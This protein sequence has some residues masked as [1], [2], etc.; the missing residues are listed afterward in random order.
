[1]RRWSRLGTLVVLVV[2]VGLTA[3][4]V[5]ISRRAGNVP[6]CPVRTAAVVLDPGHGGEDPGA[7]NDG[8]GLVER[9]LTLTIARRTAALLRADGYGV[10][11]TRD[12]DATTLANSP[13]GLI[14]NACGAL[15]YVSIHLNSFT[16]PDPNYAKVFW[17][18]ETKDRSFAEAMRAALVAGLSPGTN[19]DDGGIEQLENGG[20][21]RARMPAALVEPVF[22]SNPTE[23]ARLTAGDGVR[24]EQIAGA[25]ARGVE[26][27]LGRDAAGNRPAPPAAEHGFLRAIDSLRG[28][29]RGSAK[30]AI[31]AAEA[32]GAVRLPDVRAYMAEVYRLA[33][34]VGLD[35]AV[36]VAQSAHETGF[37]RSV[38]WKDHL[39][40]AG[41]GITNDAA[42]SPTWANGTDAARAQIVHLYLYAAGEIGPDHALAPYRS[43]D[44][45]YGVAVKAGR[46]GS[47]RTLADLAGRWASDPDYAAGV[48]RAGNELFTPASLAAVAPQGDGRA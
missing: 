1:M 39:N 47:A 36:V 35:P 32:A 23:A 40:P 37:W 6:R 44:P 12:D 9:D 16:E 38:A 42:T 20:L 29:P 18:I 33:P 14:A 13:R 45:R 25:I 27:W 2:L 26:A 41:I 28:P 30:Q 15:A 11:L 21:L 8:A 10:A 46:A 48:A 17:G 5:L 7:T 24:L 22:L 3:L 4:G 31:A 34:L 19:L 43:L